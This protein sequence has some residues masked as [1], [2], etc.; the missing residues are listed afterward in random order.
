MAACANTPRLVVNDGANSLVVKKL[1]GTAECGGVMPL[2]KNGRVTTPRAS[3]ECV[4]RADIEKLK[5]SI[6]QG[7]LDS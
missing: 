6:D 4:A 2:V 5:G 7:A 1:L 3:E